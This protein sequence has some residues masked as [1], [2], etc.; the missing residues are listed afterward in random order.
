[1]VFGR[2]FQTPDPSETRIMDFKRRQTI[3]VEPDLAIIIPAIDERENLELLLPAIWDIVTTLE[4]R[5]EII[6]V[7]GGSKDG[8][9]EAV[10]GRAARV[11][12]QKERGYG[13][14]LLA[15]FE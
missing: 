15:G 10:A 7:D 3:S 4:I 12:R 14:A 11:I 5:A 13:G 1:M 6:V 2:E 8:T 9:A